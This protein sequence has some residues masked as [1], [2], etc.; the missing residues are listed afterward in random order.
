MSQ[1]IIRTTLHNANEHTPN[2]ADIET[3]FARV[4]LHSAFY[5]YQ[6]SQSHNNYS[7][8]ITQFFVDGNI[9]YNSTGHK[10]NP[11]LQTVILL[12]CKCNPPGVAVADFHGANPQIHIE[13]IDESCRTFATAE[14]AAG[15]S[16]TE[17]TIKV[18]CEQLKIINIPE[19]EKTELINGF[20][21]R[22]GIQNED[23]FSAMCATQ[24][25]CSDFAQK[26]G[27]TNDQVLNVVVKSAVDISG[28][29]QNKGITNDQVTTAMINQNVANE[30]AIITLV[31][32]KLDTTAFA[33]NKGLSDDQILIILQQ[34]KVDLSD[35]A[36]KKGISS[37]QVL[38]VL[39][40]NGVDTSSFILDK[41]MTNDQIL[42]AL[43]NNG[44]D[45]SDFILQKGISNDQVIIILA[46]NFVDC[47]DF[48]LK[49]GI[50][51]DQV[52]ITLAKN[53]VDV[54][55]FAQ[56]KGISN[57][58][59]LLL[60]M[61]N[62]LDY[63][64]FALRR[65]MK[66]EQVLTA[67]MKNN[68]DYS[69]F[70]S[71]KSIPNEQILV[72][73]VKSG[74]D[75]LTFAQSKGFTNDQVLITLMKAKID[76]Q[77]F[78]AAKNM[79]NA[80]VIEIVQNSDLPLLD[81]YELL[82]SIQ[83]V[84]L[85]SEQENIN[86]A[87]IKREIELVIERVLKFVNNKQRELILEIVFKEALLQQKKNEDDS[88]INEIAELKLQ[89]QELQ[90]QNLDI[91]LEY[92]QKLSERKQQYDTELI[93]C[94]NELEVLK[95]EY[96]VDLQK[97]YYKY[98][99]EIEQLKKTVEAESANQNKIVELQQKQRPSDQDI[100]INDSIANQLQ[101]ECEQLKQQLI[102]EKQFHDNQQELTQ[103]QLKL[104]TQRN[105][106]LQ[107]QLTEEKT[108]RLLFFKQL[109][110]K[111]S[112]ITKLL[113][114]T[115]KEQATRIVYL[116]NE[117]QS[118][119]NT[120]ITLKEQI[121]KLNVQEYQKRID[122]QNKQIEDKNNYIS[123]L[124]EEIETINVNQLQDKQIEKVLTLLKTLDVSK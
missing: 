33:Q 35:F 122:L 110:Q 82:Q 36:G 24:Y 40:K 34:N 38:V 124:K 47:S 99:A 16:V 57:D 115:V 81:K 117:N 104:I 32:S 94:K 9:G 76:I 118:L 31:K 108:Q 55:D 56:K 15:R 95:N 73:L 85:R 41:G 45:V 109:Q 54:S 48:A 27:I 64:G 123:T 97:E 58:Q 21:Q 13:T 43:V 19:A 119:Q 98:K 69:S 8:L 62:N 106:E 120:L 107:K 59:V 46:K 39:T 74:L 114:S 111:Q 77:P 4:A 51:N 78:T 10:L 121:E 84:D 12:N 18:L 91:K 42:T 116:E 86:N 53:G 75:Y 7:K 79:S 103:Q 14:K 93:K 25:D 26:K 66:D 102:D 11:N 67:F 87:L 28:F 20:I 1:Q 61:K 89:I 52:I 101:I 83:P 113:E 17:L 44:I 90:K 37:D 100:D 71:S 22:R 70:A 105:I 23:V 49:K 96:Q 60:L 68:L 5:Q 50:S 29:V 6:L 63:I 65:G 80:K 112:E 92:E 30:T 88:A 72:A 2:A 3:V